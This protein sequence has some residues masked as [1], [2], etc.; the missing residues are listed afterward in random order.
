VVVSSVA[1]RFGA[2]MEAAYSATKFAQIGL[3]EAL[4]A[5]LG[6]RGIGVSIIDPG[7]VDTGF[8]ET[9]GHASDQSFPKPISAEQ[10]AEAVISAVEHNRAET[11][12]PGWFKAALA[13]RH[14]VPSAYRM[15]TRRR[16]RTQ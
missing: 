15:G 10:V 9:R 2:P 5:E 12:V 11:F 13:V 1:G 16:F 6:D 7:V 8:F 14:V 4:A 3:T